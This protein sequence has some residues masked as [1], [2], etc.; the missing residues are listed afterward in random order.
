MRG[1]LTNEQEG[2]VA[3]ILESLDNINAP[4]Q[5]SIDGAGGTGKIFIYQCLLHIFRGRNLSVIPVAW[6]GI[7]VNL[8]KGGR[9]SHSVFK[10]SLHLDETSVS[11]IKPNSA[12]AARL[13]EVVLIIWD[14]APMAPKIAIC[15]LDRLLKDLMRSEV[16]FGGKLIIFG[17]YFRQVLPVVRHGWRTTTVEANFQRSPLWPAIEKRK[18]LNNMRTGPGEGDSATGSLNFVRNSDCLICRHRKTF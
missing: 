6:T 12:E 15:V 16:K 3:E 2:I 14:E 8:L 5:F 10:F 7:A 4:K 1:Q 17:R 13:R 9:T 18:L 11:G